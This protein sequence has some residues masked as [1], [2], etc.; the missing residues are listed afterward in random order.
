[1][2]VLDLKNLQQQ[3]KKAFC[4][5]NCTKLFQASQYFCKFWA[6]HLEF[7]Q[8]FWIVR[9]ILAQLVRRIMETKYQLHIT[10]QFH[11]LFFDF[12]TFPKYVRRN[13]KTSH[14]FELTQ[15]FESDSIN[16]LSYSYHRSFV[17]HRF[18]EH[19]RLGSRIS[20]SKTLLFFIFS[21]LIFLFPFSM[22]SFLSCH[23]FE[24]F[25]YF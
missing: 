22:V 17:L 24:S 12:P 14:E 23:P 11:E 19:F 10:R 18:K 6:F 5:K 15:T 4:F 8:F 16:V 13:Q 25:P 1:M 7:Q 2:Y 21:N 3:V 9:A 20:C